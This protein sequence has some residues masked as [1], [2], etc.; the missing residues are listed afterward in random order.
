[1]RCFFYTRLFFLL[2]FVVDGHREKL[3]GVCI[4]THKSLCMLVFCIS[5]LLWGFCIHIH[6]S[7]CARVCC[8]YAHIYAHI[9]NICWY[10]QKKGQPQVLVHFTCFTSTKVQILTWMEAGHPQV[11][12]HC[13][14]VCW[15][16][17]TYADVCW[18]ADVC[19]RMLTY[20]DVCWHA[21]VCWRVLT[22]A[23][24]C[25]RMLTYAD[26]CGGGRTSASS[27]SSW[28]GSVGLAL[29]RQV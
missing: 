13:G 29:W 17:L 26:V 15:R 1:M 19:W 5:M 7:I 8:I 11:L 27:L 6:T 9:L 24:V 20:A 3:W 10:T 28:W 16:M 12:C 18:H 2:F 22:Y 23:D 21:D 25:W 14:D 4:H